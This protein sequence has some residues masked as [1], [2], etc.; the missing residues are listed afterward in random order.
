M[1]QNYFTPI[2][3]AY[4]LVISNVALNFNFHFSETYGQVKFVT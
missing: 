4:I 3:E 1:I 2:G